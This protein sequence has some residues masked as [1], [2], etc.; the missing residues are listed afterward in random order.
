MCGGI[1]GHAQNKPTNLEKGQMECDFRILNE[2][3]R[4]WLKRD[5]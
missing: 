1:R 3:R 4:R 2:T 5:G